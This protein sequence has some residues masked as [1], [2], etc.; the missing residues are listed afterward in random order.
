MIKVYCVYKITNLLNKKSYIGKTKA[1][2]N[3]RWKDHIRTAYSKNNKNIKQ[4]VGAVHKAIAKYKVE[5]FSF[6]ILEYFESEKDA[7]DKEVIYISQ[8]DSYYHGYNETLGGQAV[9]GAA[10]KLT[11]RQIYFVFKDYVE[12]GM[13]SSDI[14]DKY[15][16]CK[17][18]ILDIL[19][20][21][22]YL[23]ISVP[24]EFV[25]QAWLK[26]RCG[27]KQSQDE[28]Y[29]N[30]KQYSARKM[31]VRSIFDD[32]ISENYTIK[33][34][35]EKHSM[36][37]GNLYFIL[38][39]ETYKNIKIP[40][41][42]IKKT[43]K[44]L[45][46]IEKKSGKN[47]FNRKYNDK[48]IKQIFLS[49]SEGTTESKLVKQ[50]ATS[51]IMISEILYRKKYADIEICNKVLNKVNE[52]LNKRRPM[53]KFSD[54]IIVNIFDMY[55]NG[56]NTSYIAEYYKSNP[57]KI[58]RILRREIYNDVS[59][60]ESLKDLVLEKINSKVTRNKKYSKTLLYNMAEDIILG[61]SYKNIEKKY[62]VDPRT[63]RK[64]FENKSLLDSELQ[65]KVDLEI[66]R[67][68]LLKNNRKIV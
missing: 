56:Y 3:R 62:H 64:L 43:N 27:K 38:N 25:Y 9:K 37:V 61:I 44:L 68:D 40:K 63:M 51:S 6:E 1:N 36:V 10:R 57:A 29:K 58:V 34:L 4:Y 5:N 39:R 66:N 24:D 13:S 33:Q 35:A 55:G 7:Y 16:L 19:H 45:L 21:R 65:D 49:Y 28:N 59:I 48:D 17:E 23:D 52:I 50:F 15:N 46:E 54:E 22:S 41:D 47:P 53:V 18:S 32:F 30:K 2:P 8:F 12:N 42:I 67:R 26:L 20:R 14:V 31:K 11:N 60:L